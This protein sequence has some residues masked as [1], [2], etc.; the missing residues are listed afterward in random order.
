MRS[1]KSSVENKEILNSLDLLFLLDQAKR[2]EALKTRK[3]KNLSTD[4]YEFL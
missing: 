3:N 2:K 1:V 4:I